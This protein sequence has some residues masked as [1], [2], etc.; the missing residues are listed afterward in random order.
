MVV[1][2]SLV[3]YGA[4]SV[5]AMAVC[6]AETIKHAHELEDAYAALEAGRQTAGG[7]RLLVRPLCSCPLYPPT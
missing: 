2:R 5:L 4:V 7:R 1:S 3:F 6:L